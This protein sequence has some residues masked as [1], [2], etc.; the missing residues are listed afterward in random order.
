M[1]YHKLNPLITTRY[2][3]FVPVAWNG[4]ISMRVELYGCKQGTSGGT[5]FP[6]AIVTNKSVIMNQNGEELRDIS[7]MRERCIISLNTGKNSKYVVCKVP[8]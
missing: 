8:T 4:N 5:T 6:K 7:T 2:I 3:R 1:V